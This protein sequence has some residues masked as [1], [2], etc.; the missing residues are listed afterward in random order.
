MFGDQPSLMLILMNPRHSLAFAALVAGIFGVL[1][2]AV[3]GNVLE[4]F[5]APV[6]AD[7]LIL[8][9]DVGVLYLMT[10]F[11]AMRARSWSPGPALQ[12][13]VL[14]IAGAQ[15]LEALTN[16]AQTVVGNLGP[17]AWPGVAIHAAVALALLSSLR[18][19]G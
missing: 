15:V 8:A 13:A 10:A 6:H 19:S 12:T 3:P 14:A 11:I 7:G 5:G 17:Q 9:R 18:K 4:G 2:L 1:M 16:G